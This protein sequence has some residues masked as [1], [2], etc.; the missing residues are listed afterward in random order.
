FKEEFNEDSY[1]FLLNGRIINKRKL[2][3][4]KL[5]TGDTLHIFLPVF[6]G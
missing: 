4:T 3:Q 2:G 1:I 6:G 5:S